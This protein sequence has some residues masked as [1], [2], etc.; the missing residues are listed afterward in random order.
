MNQWLAAG[1]VILGATACGHSPTQA[2]NASN[3]PPSVLTITPATGLLKIGASATFSTFAVFPDG[4]GQTIAAEWSIDRPAVATV[5]STGVVT[6]LAPGTATLMARTAGRSASRSLRVI[7][8]YAGSWEGTRTVIECLGGDPGV[9]TPTPC[10]TLGVCP[11]SYT[12]GRTEELLAVLTHRDDQVTGFVS[13]SA[14]VIP[15][16]GA[17]DLDGTLTLEGVLQRSDA[18]GSYETRVTE[19]KTT[20][21]PTGTMRGGFVVVLPSFSNNRTTSPARIRY[22]IVSLRRIGIARARDQNA[23][24]AASG[25]QR[26]ARTRGLNYGGL[27]T[28]RERASYNR[29]LSGTWT[30][31]ASEGDFKLTRD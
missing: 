11:P 18:V 12:P 16:T 8:D 15:S 31:V 3:V 25:A 10:P 7:P 22:Q 28:R 17:I 24:S 26:P 20:L 27:R 30:D 14:G 29:T 13:L 19:W 1:A 21:D 6:A 2:T 9:C 4:S 23:Q 5:Q